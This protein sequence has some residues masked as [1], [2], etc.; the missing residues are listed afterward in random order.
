MLAIILILNSFYLKL[1]FSV[2]KIRSGGSEGRAV[3][4]GR[5]AHISESLGEL[6]GRVGEG[7]SML[8]TEQFA[9]AHH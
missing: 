3:L 9:G 4:K 1:S 5:S 6:D 8:A 2:Y 7:D